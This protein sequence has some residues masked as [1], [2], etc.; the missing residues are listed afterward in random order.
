M[1]KVSVCI[2]VYNV[3]HYIGRC[4]ESILCQSLKDIEI[5]VVNDCTPDSSMDIVR[6]YASEDNRIKMIEHSENHGQMVARRTGYMKATGD[7]ITFCDS[8]DTL[9]DGALEALYNK[10]V[11]EN[12]DVVSGVIEYIPV[13]GKRYC[14]KNEL[15]YGTDKIAVY[16][17]VLTNEFGHNLCSRLFRREILQSYEYETYERATNGEDGMLFYQVVDYVSKVVAIDKIVYEYWQN[18]QSSSQV[19]L[20]D[21]ALRS[22]ALG[23]AMRKKTSG[24]YENLKHITDRKISSTYW[25]LRAHGY[26]IGKF[27][28]EVGLCGYDGFWNLLRIQGFK[29]SMR[30]FLQ[31]RF[32]LIDVLRSKYDK[33]M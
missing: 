29:G 32:M 21:H 2:P 19:R 33:S 24:K 17:S 23:N 12:A 27:Y 10:A 18:L 15:S 26:D 30:I 22:I 5:I 7:Y 31:F 4:L 9:A 28:S 6:K 1:P 25:G 13:K 3:E 16:R 8:D 14:W 11:M 20:K